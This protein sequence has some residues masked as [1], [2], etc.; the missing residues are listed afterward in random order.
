MGLSFSVPDDVKIPPSLKNIFKEI[1]D[2]CG[3]SDVYHSGNL[4]R[5]AKQ[6]VLLLNT[7]LTVREGKSNS[8]SKLWRKYTDNIIKYISNNHNGCI[9]ILW[10]GNAIK[11]SK[12]ID[13]S[14]HHVISSVHPSPLSCYRGFFGSKPFT[15]AN[16]ILISNNK[17]PIIW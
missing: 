13:I 11:K 12:Y 16:N 10:G 14:R 1:K 5:L 4:I 2:D 3:H 8:H 15:K 7:S 9:F 17:Q 6:G